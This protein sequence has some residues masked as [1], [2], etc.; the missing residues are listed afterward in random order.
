MKIGG[1]YLKILGIVRQQCGTL[2]GT[3][4]LYPS[5]VQALLLQRQLAQ[6]TQE[7]SVTYERLNQDVLRKGTF[8]AVS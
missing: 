7:L 6:A 3:P 8:K 5:T 1:P 4:G 2:N